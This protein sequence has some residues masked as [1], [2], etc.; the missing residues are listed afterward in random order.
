LVYI[1]SSRPV[2]APKWGASS[3]NNNNNNKTR[4]KP[5]KT[6]RFCFT[7]VRM[8]IIRKTSDSKCRGGFYC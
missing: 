8:A 1:V 6:P 2:R 7:P 3:N 5:N 4:T